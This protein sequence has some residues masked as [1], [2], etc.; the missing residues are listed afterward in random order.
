M[1]KSDPHWEQFKMAVAELLR[2][3][4][5]R[6]AQDTEAETAMLNTLPMTTEKVAPMRARRTVRKEGDAVHTM[7]QAA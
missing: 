1:N 4:L 5:E 3:R 2:A 7:K 6:L